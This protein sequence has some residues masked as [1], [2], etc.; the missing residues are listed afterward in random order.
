M[1]VTASNRSVENLELSLAYTYMNAKDK[2]PGTL[3]DQVQY[4]PKH[5]LALQGS[6]NFPFDLSAYAS[7]ERI[8]D[9]YY[10]NS[11]NTLKGKL[12]DYTVVNLKVEKKFFSRALKIFAG[13]NNLF[14]ENY[15]ESY[16]LPR[17]GRSV[18]CG[19]KYS[20]N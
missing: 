14:D 5:K 20:F 12:P 1:E 19:F 15:Y 8:T 17:E 16:G 3:V 13:A 7:I 2:S 18:Y 11:D 4:N 9:Q 10:Y 6:Y